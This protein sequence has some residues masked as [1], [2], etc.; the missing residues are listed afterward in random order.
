MHLRKGF[1]CLLIV[2][3]SLSFIHSI[4]AQDTTTVDAKKLVEQ[5]DSSLYPDVYK[6]IIVIRNQK[7][8]SPTTTKKTTFWRDG[9]KMLSII[10][11]PRV[12]KGQALLRNEDDMWFF[13][14]KSR[15]IT[16]IGAKDNSF[17]GQ[18]SNADL[19]R[20]DL[21]DDYNH[22]VMGKE[23]ENGQLCWK[24]ELKGIKRTVA[25]DK[26]I[27][28]ISVE[29]IFPV[30]RKFYSISGQ[31]LK[32]MTFLDITNSNNRQIP[33]TIEI[34]NELNTDYKTTLITKELKVLNH[35]PGRMFTTGWLE[36]G[37]SMEY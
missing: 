14:P 15:Q 29:H 28:W 11:A 34:V 27:Y 1:I 3:F 19:L 25:Y 17:G 4:I 13:L 18:A 24:L 21:A 33:K 36:S 37:G 22:R 26:I 2:L 8:G 35:I 12:Q 20:V 31:K 5:A 7:S 30:K 32:T 6:S 16:K 10:N 9:D 23:M